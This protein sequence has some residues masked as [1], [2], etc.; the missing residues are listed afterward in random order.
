MK[1]HKICEY[2]NELGV[3]YFTVSERFMFFFWI[4]DKILI[5]NG[6]DWAEEL[7]KFDTY[8]A[9]LEHINKPDPNSFTLKKSTLV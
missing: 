8:E 9:A 3:K 1:K 6:L 4:P 5:P 2:E 7:M